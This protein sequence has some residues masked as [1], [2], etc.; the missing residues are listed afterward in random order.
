MTI[1]WKEIYRYDWPTLIHTSLLLYYLSDLTLA[2]ALKNED[3]IRSAHWTV[4]LL[5][6]F[7]INPSSQAFLLHYYEHENNSWWKL[8]LLEAIQEKHSHL[9]VKSEYSLFQFTF[10]ASEPQTK[11]NLAPSIIDDCRKLNNAGNQITIY[12]HPLA[13]AVMIFF[14]VFFIHTNVL[15]ENQF[16]VLAPPR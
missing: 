3:N 6:L 10:F 7:K 11:P 12:L 15:S 5:M 2:T 1:W 4:V 9:W 14:L 8:M 13:H 16:L